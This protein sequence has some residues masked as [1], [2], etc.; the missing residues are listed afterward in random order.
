MKKFAVA[1]VVVLMTALAADFAAAENLT[2]KLGITGRLGF[3]V[4]ADGDTGFIFGGG[5]MYGVT[6]NLAAELDV[7]HSVYDLWHGPYSHDGTV[8]VTNLS[9]GVQWR[10]VMDRP[11]TPYAGGGLSILFNDYS[12]ADADTTVGIN[13]KGGID[14]YINP[15][16][17]LNAELKWTISPDAD[18]NYGPGYYNGSFDPSSL[19]GLFGVRYF[20]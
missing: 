16:V 20:F 8:N 11:F 17:A 1:V 15:K 7:T 10:F 5:F 18:L 19:S 12:D 6:R 9:L 13:I 3:T 2:N 4:P 14:Y